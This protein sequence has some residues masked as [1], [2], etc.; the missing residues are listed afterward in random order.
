MSRYGGVIALTLCAGAANAATTL[1]LDW[2]SAGPLH[3]APYVPPVYETTAVAVADGVRVTGHLGPMPASDFVDSVLIAAGTM[4]GPIRPGDQLEVRYAVSATYP[5]GAVRITSMNIG[6]ILYDEPG[7]MTVSE[8]FGEI[9][10]SPI[11]LTSGATVTGVFRSTPFT[12]PSS[13]GE[14]SLAWNVSWEGAPVSS[15]PFSFV[16]QPEGFR[17]RVIRG[18]PPCPG[19]TNADLVVN[20]ADL[21]IVLAQYGMQSYPGDL[22][23]DLDANGVVNFTDLNIVLSA[24]GS[25]C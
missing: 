25:A 6:G 22:A 24:Y 17:V 12:A 18:G 5:L 8:V 13:D 15:D 20:F 4:T 3:G 9:P 11:T 23:G 1:S 10:T 2:T 19:D 21:N 16:F 7:G 14:W